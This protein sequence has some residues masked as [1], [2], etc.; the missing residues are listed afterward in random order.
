MAGN[1]GP[2]QGHRQT[3]Q[4]HST[5]DWMQVVSAAA[6]THTTLMTTCRQL[7]RYSVEYTNTNTWPVATGVLNFGEISSN[8]YK[9]IV[10]IGYIMV[11]AYCDLDL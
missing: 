10:F 7:R 5:K 11:I 2:V 9:D 4:V 8:I 6:Q 1:Y 3:S